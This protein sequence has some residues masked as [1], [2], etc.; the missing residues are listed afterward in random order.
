MGMTYQQRQAR[1]EAR[2]YGKRCKVALDHFTFHQ[3]EASQWLA[4]DGH[5]GAL[6]TMW[7][8]R[9]DQN[10]EDAVEYAVKAAHHARLSITEEIHQQLEQQERAS[11]GA[12]R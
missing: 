11:A 6:T 4:L 10:A 3:H 5:S 9:A 7:Q 1:Q 2:Y 12:E 8:K